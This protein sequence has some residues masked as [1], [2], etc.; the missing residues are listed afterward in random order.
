MTAQAA[1]LILLACLCVGM[2]LGTTFTVQAIQ[3]RLRRQAAERRRLN[4]EWQAVREA[5]QSA[6]SVRCARCGYRLPAGTWYI[7]EEDE[8]DDDDDD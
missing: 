7:E 2:L 8:P 4:A 1:G 6:Q 5:Q 3:P